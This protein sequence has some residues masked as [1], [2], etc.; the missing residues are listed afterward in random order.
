MADSPLLN[1]YYQS[2]AYQLETEGL[3]SIEF[4]TQKAKH[5]LLAECIKF[6][7]TKSIEI[8]LDYFDAPKDLTL[9]E[10]LCY[11]QLLGD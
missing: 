4:F 9:K 10:K 2:K 11:I 1:A 3:S 7:R 8:L 5:R 6:N